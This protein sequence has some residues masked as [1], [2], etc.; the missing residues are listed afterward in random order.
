[1]K[2]FTVISIFA[3]A[4]SPLFYTEPDEKSG[5]EYLSY[6]LRGD[7][8]QFSLPPT[9]GLSLNLTNKMARIGHKIYDIESCDSLRRDDCI[10]F[11]N[12]LI[13]N[14][15]SF[16]SSTKIGDFSLRKY[17]SEF[18][19]L[20]HTVVGVLTMVIGPNNEVVNHYFWTEERGII[21]LVFPIDESTHAQV[22]ILSGNAGMFGI[23]TL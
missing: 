4:V 11:G 9:L 12:W 3:L 20:G 10:R 1:M 5:F 14:P 16:D 18:N 21:A 15:G 7:F 8:A 17:A 2:L 6:G 22:F 23:K 19:V 13:V